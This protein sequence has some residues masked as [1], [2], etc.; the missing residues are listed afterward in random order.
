MARYEVS[1]QEFA[2]LV[3]KEPRGS[4][5]MTVARRQ[6]EPLSFSEEVMTRARFV[7]LVYE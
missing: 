1:P 5:D 7:F 3:E 6:I 2:E 4:F